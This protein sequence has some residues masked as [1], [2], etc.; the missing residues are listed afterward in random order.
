MTIYHPWRRLLTELLPI[1]HRTSMKTFG[2]LGLP[3]VALSRRAGVGTV[4]FDLA[5]RSKS[6]TVR[7]TRGVIDPQSRSL[8]AFLVRARKISLRQGNPTKW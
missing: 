6:T 5:G 2:A 3:C 1:K 4:R 7:N 8:T